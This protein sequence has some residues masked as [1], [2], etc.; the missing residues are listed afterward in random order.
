MGDFG[1]VLNGKDSVFGVEL[2]ETLSLG[3]ISKQDFALWC[4]HQ[5]LDSPSNGSEK[6]C[7]KTE[8]FDAALAG[9]FRWQAV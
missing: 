4:G 9:G 7:C 8:G 1:V 2:P 5:L 3:D 6:R